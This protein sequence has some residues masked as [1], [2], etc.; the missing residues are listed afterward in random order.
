MR[1]RLL[2]FLCCPLCRSSLKVTP[3]EFDRNGH[4]TNGLLGCSCGAEFPIIKSI[5]RILP[6]DLRSQHFL[7]HQEYQERFGQRLKPESAV[8]PT[9]MTRQKLRTQ[10]SFGYE[11]TKF[12][13]YSAENFSAFIRPL[14][15]VVFT[16]KLGL[17]VGC[18]A[19]RHVQ[20]A[21][22]LGAEI[23][24]L[25]L[26]NSIDVAY[27]L[28]QNNT[29][30]HFIQGD[31][32]HLPFR[33]NLFDFIYSLGVLHHLL[34]PEDGF[35]QLIPHLKP[36]GSI[37]IWVYQRTFRKEVLESIRRITT[38]LPLGLLM[39]LAWL[40][41]VVDYGAI[42]NL[43]RALRRFP[44]VVDWAPLRIKEYASYNFY[45]SYA[46]WFDRL[47]APISHCYTEM[48]IRGWF[49]SA[50]LTEVETALVGDSW[51]W[52]KGQRGT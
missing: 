23:I 6:S 37:F 15:R 31:V 19:G 44:V 48:E 38:H 8:P 36:G 12:S 18:G 51:V 13:K 25:D 4:V 40:A 14:E 28:N 33:Q 21:T 45:T 11:W 22:S 3:F 32:F 41:A 9:M 24:G 46:D 17:D 27:D 42:V 7:L 50:G 35:R 29:A 43:Y 34:S 10:A 39:V 30:A 16:N 20:Q 1:I 47:S 5:P 2:D 49:L 26:S 52:A